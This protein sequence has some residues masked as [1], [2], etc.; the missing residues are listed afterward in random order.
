MLPSVNSVP[1]LG[2][3]LA[4]WLVISTWSPPKSLAWQKGFR[5]GSGL[6]WR[7]L[8][9]W[10]LVYG[11]APPVS[12]M[13]VL[14]VVIAGISYLVSL[15]LLLLFF[16]VLFRLLGGLL[17]TLRFGLFLTVA[18]GLVRLLSLFNALLFGLPL[19]CLLLIRV[20]VPS[21]LRLKGF[22]DLEVSWALATGKQPGSTCMREWGSGG[23]ARRVFMVGC[24]LAAAAA[25]SCRVESD[26]WVAPHLAVRAH[27]ESAC[28]TYFC[29]L[30]LGCLLLIRVEVLSRWRSRGF[31]RSSS[32]WPGLMRCRW[33]S[34]CA[35]RF[36]H[37]VGGS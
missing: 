4:C 37:R 15:L 19:A 29:G 17:L 9:H 25:S 10:L 30:L 32:S 1:L 28:S 7:R 21:L 33:M 11:L 12:G 18:G 6:T 34:L 14:P 3:N 2:G 13:G 26:G 23:G 5:L 35:G 27:F 24:P 8:G 16:P 31:G 36:S 22:V 20:R